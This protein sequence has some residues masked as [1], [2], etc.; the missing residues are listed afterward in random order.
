MY[1]AKYV[2]TF[3]ISGEYQEIKCI[4]NSVVPAHLAGKKAHDL[5]LVNNAILKIC[6]CLYLVLSLSWGDPDPGK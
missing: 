1:V 6:F 2:W 3:L 4:N 5:I